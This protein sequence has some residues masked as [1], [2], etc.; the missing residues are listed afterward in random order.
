MTKHKICLFFRAHSPAVFY[1][2]SPIETTVIVALVL[3]YALTIIP[4]ILFTFFFCCI[5]CF[6][7]A[8]SS[9]LLI[10][11][12][13]LTERILTR[14]PGKGCMTSKFFF[15]STMNLN[16]KFHKKTYLIVWLDK[17]LQVGSFFSIRI[18]KTLLHFHVE[19]RV[20]LFEFLLIFIY[21]LKSFKNVTF[22]IFKKLMML[23]LV[24]GSFLYLL[25]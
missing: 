13:V 17:E 10:Y 20:L 24:Q 18:A 21:S 19:F 23:C 4:G 16:Y 15:L 2:H 22:L 14:F 12:F 3:E 1:S 5:F 6:L 25:I 9:C 7:D 8:T 11:A